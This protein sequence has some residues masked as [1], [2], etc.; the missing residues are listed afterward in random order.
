MIT[1]LYSS[2]DGKSVEIDADSRYILGARGDMEIDVTSFG[3][4]K[5]NQCSKLIFYY[6]FD[7][8]L[9]ELSYLMLPAPIKYS[10]DE[11][12]QRHVLN[13]TNIRLL[14]SR[15]VK[16]LKRWRDQSFLPGP[17]GRAESGMIDRDLLGSLRPGRPLLVER[18]QRNRDQSSLEPWSLFDGSTRERKDVEALFSECGKLLSEC[19][20]Y[21]ERC[22]METLFALY[23]FIA[24][25]IRIQD[26]GYEATGKYPFRFDILSPLE[27]ILRWYLI[28]NITRDRFDNDYTI[29]VIHN[30]FKG[31]F[32]TR[33]ECNHSPSLAAYTYY[34]FMFRH[35]VRLAR[36]TK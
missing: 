10:V 7:I 17:D 24:F 22:I 33:A 26:S 36:G 3:L 16:V 8:S 14:A 12:K 23:A 13:H 21:S 34:M 4:A 1:R 35:W 5:A 20:I 27:V 32:S 19:G 28:A 15:C 2:I 11:I 31:C 6:S 30:W 25:S 18:P 29:N 9:T